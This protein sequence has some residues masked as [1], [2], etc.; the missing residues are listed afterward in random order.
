MGPQ[1]LNNQFLGPIVKSSS[2]RV[3]LSKK[4][5]LLMDH[6]GSSTLNQIM[7]FI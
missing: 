7:F 5:V 6:F 3:N 4:K 2:Q 1:W